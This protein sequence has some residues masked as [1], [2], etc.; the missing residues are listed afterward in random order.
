MTDTV[1]R[2]F[3]NKL[4]VTIVAFALLLFFLFPIYWL[5]VMSLKENVEIFTYPPNFFFTPTLAAYQK[6]AAANNFINA[7]YNSLIVSFSTTIICLIVGLS[8]AYSVI[9]FDFKG[10][11]ALQYMVMMLRIAPSISMVIPLYMIFSSLQIVNST[12]SV[13]IS[14]V[15][16]LLS[17]TVWLLLGYLRDVP[18]DLTYAALID[19]SGYLGILIRIVIPLSAPGIAAVGILVFSYAWNEYLI[20]SVMVKPSGQTLPVL[21]RSYLSEQS[22]IWNELAAVGVIIS[23]PAILV[24]LFCQKYIVGGLTMGAVKG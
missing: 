13:V 2:K 23:A 17:F 4:L 12:F 5:V 7:F 10:K 20:S 8:A 24:T 14:L 15:S 21:I 19:G 3:A 1:N 11:R 9:T 22:V 16:F 6:A 18:K